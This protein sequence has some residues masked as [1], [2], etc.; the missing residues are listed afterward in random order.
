MWIVV[1]GTSEWAK[2][3]DFQIIF[4][5]EI[6][7]KETKIKVSTSLLKFQCFLFDTKNIVWKSRSYYLFRVIKQNAKKMQ[8]KRHE[9]RPKKPLFLRIKLKFDSWP[10]NLISSKTSWVGPLIKVWEKLLIGYN[11]ALEFPTFFRSKLIFTHIYHFGRE[12]DSLN[13]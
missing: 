6:T 5:S 13:F 2:H 12:R 10:L 1:I 3:I 7:E 4:R 11:I 9:W 8:V